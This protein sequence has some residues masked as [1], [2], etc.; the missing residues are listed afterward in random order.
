MARGA[1]EQPRG[2]W[3]VLEWRG[4]GKREMLPS[5]KSMKRQFTFIVETFSK[6]NWKTKKRLQL[7]ARSKKGFWTNLPRPLQCGRPRTDWQHTGQLLRSRSKD[8]YSKKQKRRDRLGYS[9]LLGNCKCKEGREC[10]MKTLIPQWQKKKQRS[11]SE[12]LGF[13]PNV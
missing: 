10:M 11:V 1:Q 2:P 5:Q 6:L 9:H 12:S 3:L 4:K 7:Y 8:F 13:K